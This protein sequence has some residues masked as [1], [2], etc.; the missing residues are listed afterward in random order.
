[1]SSTPSPGDGWTP[2]NSALESASP[3]TIQ[4]RGWAQG[5]VISARLQAHL[6]LG[7]ASET[8]ALVVSHDC[9]VVNGS[10]ELE[11]YVEVLVAKR[12]ER[13]DGNKLRGKNPRLIQLT[14]SAGDSEDVLIEASAY[15]RHF[16]DRRLLATDDPAWTIGVRPRTELIR[17]LAARYVRA[18]FPDAFNERIALAQK[19]IA[20]LVKRS[21]KHLSG[22]YILVQDDELDSGDYEIQVRAT[23][24][25]E[26]HDDLAK[27][28][29]C[30]A[31]LDKVVTA[32]NEC[33]GIDVY[34]HRVVS[35]A[36]FSLDDLRL[37][38]RWDWDHISLKQDPAESMAPNP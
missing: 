34:D 11:P 30:T 37:M 2:T 31:L 4:S 21:G 18:A 25:V 12:V 36:E 24:E 15:D 13:L 22:I 3:A 26:D 23:M 9:D 27:R 29:T 20:K 1:M 14:V 38:K 35:E 8:L 5:S 32:I 10:F 17:W 33:D 19:Q 7:D 6:N 28:K 16:V